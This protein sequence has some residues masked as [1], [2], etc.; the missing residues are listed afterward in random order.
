M[1]C[2]Y[3]GSAPA[4]S[5]TSCSRPTC[6]ISVA[7]HASVTSVMDITD[8]KSAE[9]QLRESERRFRD[10]AEA[11]GE[12]VWELDVDGRYTFLSRRVEQVLGYAPDELLGRRP[13]DLMPPGEAERV[14][15]SFAQIM[16]TR[17]AFRNLEHRSMSR[18]GSQVWQLVS[19]VPIVDG[20]GPVHRLPGHGARHH[21]AEAG[22]VAHRGARH[23]RSADRAAES[24][25]ALRPPRARHRRRAARGRTA[26][27][28]VRRPGS[29]QAHQRHARPRH[30]GPAAARGREA[31][32]RR[33][34]QGR[35]AV[36]ARRRRVRGR[37]RGAEG[38]GGR[39]A[40]RAQADRRG[41][42][43]PTI[44]RATRSTP[45]RARGSR[46]TRPTAPMGRR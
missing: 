24:A 6:S 40:S 46:S 39:R 26:R 32:R 23:A 21:R 28:D 38:G 13:T 2:R 36:A 1:E 11:A 7:R 29:L 41:C 20:E 14:R 35:Y 33:A 31:H 17:E 16:R 4:R 5:R 8:R 43:S 9:R 25:P 34:A 37:A 42:R 27:G 18:S 15:D 19:G 22:R 45:R 44:S 3:C 12:Y 30:R 10:F